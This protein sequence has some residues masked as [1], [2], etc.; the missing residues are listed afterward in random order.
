MNSRLIGLFGHNQ[1]T[2]SILA[3]WSLLRNRMGTGLLNMSDYR[4]TGLTI[5]HSIVGRTVHGHTIYQHRPIVVRIE[6]DK[7]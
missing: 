4:I 6:R 1:L 3:I 2:C 7:K 5:D